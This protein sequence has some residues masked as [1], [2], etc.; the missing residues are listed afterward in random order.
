MFQVKEITDNVLMDPTFSYLRQ[1]GDSYVHFFLTDGDMILKADFHPATVGGMLLVGAE[2]EETLRAEGISQGIMVQ[3]IQE[4]VFGCNTSKKII[5]KVLVAEGTLPVK[6]VPSYWRLQPELFENVQWELMGNQRLDYKEIQPFAVVHAHQVL[7]HAIVPK[8]GQNG[9]TVKSVKIPFGKKDIVKLLP[10]RNTLVHNGVAYAKISGRMIQ[11]GGYFHL[12]DY[13]EVENVD[14]T[15]GHIEFPGHMTIRH[16]VL[17]GF[18]VHVGG[19]LKINDTLDAT[20]V[21]VKKNLFVHGGILGRKEGLL[22]V[23]GNLQTDFLENTQTEILGSADIKKAVLHSEVLVNGDFS[24][25]EAGKIISSHLSVKGNCDIH[26]IGNESNGARVTVGVDFV[27]RRKSDRLKAKIVL[28]E[29]EKLEYEAHK[30]REPT[31]QKKIDEIHGL[32]GPL[33]EEMNA[34]NTT[35]IKRDSILRVKGALFSGAVIEIGFATLEVKENMN[36][37]QFSLSEE[38]HSIVMEAYQAPE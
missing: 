16:R 11:E 20:D 25:G 21:Y 4:A 36:S 5:E 34:L 13:L 38:G 10:G 19:D 29:T 24:M 30:I 15:T 26:Q 23:G 7:A 37:R 14:Y 18:R 32:L 31:L 27:L 3:N 1:E 17:E 33:V 9:I 6:E 2:L 35:M 22:R 12:D 28:L 8:P